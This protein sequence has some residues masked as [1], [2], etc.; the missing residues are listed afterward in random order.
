MAFSRRIEGCY[1]FHA[2]P[3]LLSGL[4]FLIVFLEVETQNLRINITNTSHINICNVA[5]LVLFINFILVICR[6]LCTMMYQYL[7]DVGSG[8]GENRVHIL[9]LPLPYL[10]DLG[11]SSEP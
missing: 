9:A 1:E 2:N 3:T 5:I 10:V 8:N 11:T 7:K 6:L 4:A